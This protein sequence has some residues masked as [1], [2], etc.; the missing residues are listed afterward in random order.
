MSKMV[1]YN[2]YLGTR[3]ID[4]VFYSECCEMT[5]EEVKD[6]LV[7]HDHFDPRIMVFKQK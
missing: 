3:N 5:E 4:T 1:A 7:R 6:S 2:V